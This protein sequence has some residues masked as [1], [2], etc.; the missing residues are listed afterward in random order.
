MCCGV[1]KTANSA[2]YDI[3]INGNWIKMTLSDNAESGSSGYPLRPMGELTCSIQS[4]CRT[5]EYCGYQ[6]L[7]GKNQIYFVK[8]FL[9]RYLKLFAR[10]N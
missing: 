7:W 9:K 3:W 2:I 4:T 1:Y 10:Q 8:R 6:K 5:I